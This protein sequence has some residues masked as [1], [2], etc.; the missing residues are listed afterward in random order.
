ML[1]LKQCLTAD[2][3]I[4]CDDLLFIFCYE[5]RRSPMNHDEKQGGDRNKSVTFT[6]VAQYGDCVEAVSHC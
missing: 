2:S 1:T 5:S 6:E 4:N 3:P